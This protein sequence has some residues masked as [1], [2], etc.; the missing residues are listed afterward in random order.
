MR[1]IFI[2]GIIGAGKSTNARRIADDLGRRGLGA[3][4]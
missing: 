4:W 2:E 1:L 3:H